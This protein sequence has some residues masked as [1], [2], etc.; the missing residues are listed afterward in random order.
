MYGFIWGCQDKYMYLIESQTN[1]N[2]HSFDL[3]LDTVICATVVQGGRVMG[4][5]FQ[6]FVSNLIG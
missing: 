4:G 3:P 1:A 6:M 2:N 5:S